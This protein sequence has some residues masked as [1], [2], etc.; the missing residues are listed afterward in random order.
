MNFL[1]QIELEAEAKTRTPPRSLT[2]SNR[3]TRYADSDGWSASITND[4]GRV[5]P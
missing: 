4:P 1:T 2:T 5:R 3:P